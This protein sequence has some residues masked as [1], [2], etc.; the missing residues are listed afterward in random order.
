MQPPII[1]HCNQGSPYSERAKLQLDY[2]NLPWHG[3]LTSKGVPRPTLE[4]LV[5]EYSRRVPVLQVG[6]DLYC[7]ATGIAEAT[8]DLSD[9]PELSPWK[10]TKEAQ[11]L[12]LQ[13]EQGGNNAILSSLGIMD[14]LIGYFRHLPFADA[15]EFFKDRK[16]LVNSYPDLKK[17]RDRDASIN[18]KHNYFAILDKSLSFYKY[19][20]SR[21]NV[22]VLD[23]A[24]YTMIWYQDMLTNSR[25]IRQYKNIQSW[26]TQMSAMRKEA[27]SYI[28]SAD[29]L[30][31]AKSCTPSDIPAYMKQAPNLGQPISV[32]PNDTLGDVLQLAITGVLVGE[33]DNKFIVARTH[34]KTGTV[35]IHLPKQCFGACG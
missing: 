4:S 18:L 35:H 9:K 12:L 10:L 24:A 22:S 13:I 23:F 2:A 5:G 33:N 30:A 15:I 32:M 3:C 26:F 19:L 6:A 34:N 28:S 21:D 17:L 29:A 1:L 31:T 8:A 14:F 25:F 20:G 7:D 11:T 16:A 27:P